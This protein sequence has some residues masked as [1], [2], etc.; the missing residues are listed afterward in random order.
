MIPE[1]NSF[2]STGE[3]NANINEENHRISLLC[4]FIC[5]NPDRAFSPWPALS[6]SNAEA[7]DLKKMINLSSC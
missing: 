4:F 3:F 5:T 2:S 6:S 1:V 7:L